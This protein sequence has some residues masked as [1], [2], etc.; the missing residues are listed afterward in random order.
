[1]TLTQWLNVILSHPLNVSRMKLAVYGLWVMPTFS[2][3]QQNLPTNILLWKINIPLSYS[4]TLTASW[5]EGDMK[6][7][8]IAKRLLCD[9]LQWNTTSL[10]SPSHGQRIGIVL[11]GRQV[12]FLYTQI[13]KWSA[14][15]ST[16]TI[17]AKPHSK[18]GQENYDQDDIFSRLAFVIS[19]SWCLQVGHSSR[20]SPIFL[21]FDSL[22]GVG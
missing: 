19:L 16:G 3:S 10:W 13:A 17:T 7:S 6:N 22:Y 12:V 1:M 15:S 14:I 5:V 8:D 21:R 9:S 11:F 18:C 2:T 20:D 4:I